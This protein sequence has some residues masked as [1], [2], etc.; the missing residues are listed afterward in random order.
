MGATVYGPEGN[1]VGTVASVAGGLVTVDT[2]KHKVPLATDAF[3]EGDKGPTITVTKAQLDAMMDEQLAKAAAARD[4]LLVPGTAVETADNQ[5]LGTIE[6]V[7]GD[8]VVVTRS[9]GPVALMRTA[10]AEANGKLIA[11]YTK[12]QIEAAVASAAGGSSAAQ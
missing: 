2:G 1:E 9:E 12:A 11:L 8:N 7:D 10:F 4:A 6:S 5:P 3:G